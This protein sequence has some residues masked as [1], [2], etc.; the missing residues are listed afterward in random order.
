MLMQHTVSSLRIKAKRVI[1]FADDSSEYGEHVG[2]CEG[3]MPLSLNDHQLRPEGIQARR[4]AGEAIE[5]H[6][7]RRH[8]GGKSCLSL[9]KALFRGPEARSSRVVVAWADICSLHIWP[10]D[11][12]SL[13]LIAVYTMRPRDGI[14]REIMM[15]AGCARELAFWGIAIAFAVTKA[16][17]PAPDIGPCSCCAQ[18]RFEG[19][20]LSLAIDLARVACEAARLRPSYEC[21][22]RLIDV[23]EMLVGADT[24]SCEG[25]EVSMIQ[26]PLPA[27]GFPLAALRR[28]CETARQVAKDFEEWQGWREVSLLVRPP[29]GFDAR[30]WHD[31]VLSFLFPR[32]PSLRSLDLYEYPTVV[33]QRLA[34]A[35]ER[36]HRKLP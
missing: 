34:N 8:V 22:R 25:G 3:G 13:N 33:D 10:S 5:E 15:Q 14:K 18:P 26:Q 30:L 7:E 20:P 27:G 35:A 28:F 23:L 19:L 21:L 6:W 12:L 29:G 24:A 36:C 4:T 11:G 31:R 16:R 9:E 32:E 2:D 17:L 1:S